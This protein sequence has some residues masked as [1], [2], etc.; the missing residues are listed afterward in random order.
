VTTGTLALGQDA[1]QARRAMSAIRWSCSRGAPSAACT[2]IPCATSVD[3]A[4]PDSAQRLAEI[5]SA[6]GNDRNGARAALIELIGGIPIGRTGTPDDIANLVA[7]LVSDE[8]SWITG[9]DYVIDG[10]LLRAA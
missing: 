6:T 8:A 10:G 9:S 4:D 2:E 5:A 1:G 7:F 3:V